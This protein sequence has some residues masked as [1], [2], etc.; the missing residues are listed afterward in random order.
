M[1]ATSSRCCL[2]VVGRGCSIAAE[3]FSVDG[4]K[5]S[6]NSRGF[7]DLDIAMGRYPIANPP[8]LTPWYPLGNVLPQS[9]G[10]LTTPKLLYLV[11]G[12]STF[13]FCWVHSASVYSSA[14]KP[15]RSAENFFL[16]RLGFRDLAS[17]CAKQMVTI[18][19]YDFRNE[20]SNHYLHVLEYRKHLCHA[21]CFVGHAAMMAM[22]TCHSAAKALEALN[23]LKA[24]RSCQHRGTSLSR[25]G[26]PPDKETYS[27]TYSSYF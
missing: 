18:S 21:Y 10:S 19:Y 22:M 4:H 24:S 7:C 16:C 11:C 9:C 15:Q 14:L 5:H 23:S 3:E 6:W 25:F 1:F 26:E 27:D 12:A 17:L 2:P 13:W 20:T 8:F